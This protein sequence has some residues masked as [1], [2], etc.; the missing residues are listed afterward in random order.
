MSEYMFSSLF[1]L[2]KMG[3]SETYFLIEQII[4]FR[5]V[6]YVKLCRRKD[7]AKFGI[8]CRK[9][10]GL[11]LNFQ[12]NGWWT[13]GR[14]RP[15]AFPGLT[16]GKEEAQWRRSARICSLSVARTGILPLLDRSSRVLRFGLDLPPMPPRRSTSADAI[17][18]IWNTVITLQ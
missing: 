1:I 3:K 4:I 5:T 9:T 7:S 18:P 6:L 10:A 12:P 14:V 11:T 16:S 17:W 8:K 13:G 15:P 2:N